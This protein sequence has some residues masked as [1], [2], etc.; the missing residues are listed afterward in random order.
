[1]ANFFWNKSITWKKN[2]LAVSVPYPEVNLNFRP[3]DLK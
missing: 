3:G 2:N 1:M